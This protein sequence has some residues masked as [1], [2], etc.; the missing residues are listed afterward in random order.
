MLRAWN[1][2]EKNTKR[3][4]RKEAFAL[5]VRSGLIFPM[6]DLSERHLPRRSYGRKK[7]RLFVPKILGFA[8]GKILDDAGRGRSSKLYCLRSC[9]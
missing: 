5:F 7:S 2:V 6:F 4:Q 9:C 3:S 1:V 8:A